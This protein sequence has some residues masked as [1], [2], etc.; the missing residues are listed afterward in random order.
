[1]SH[2]N[3]LILLPLLALAGD[4]KMLA[5]QTPAVQVQLFDYAGMKP[6]AVHEFVV[7]T[8]EILNGAG[9]SAQ[10]KLC[11]GHLAVSCESQPNGHRRL[12]IRVVAA[13]PGRMSNVRRPPLGQSFAGHEG[14]TYASVFV[15]RVQDAAAEANLSW[16]IVLAYAAV[17]E[18]GHLLLGD[19]AHTERGLMKANW[20]RKDFEAMSQ[21]NLHF[22]EEQARQLAT[23]YG[24]VK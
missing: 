14:G 11:R 6:S 16:V 9:V 10:V 21:N 15:E 20:D 8:Q 2:R 13:D 22:S 17:H 18:A 3:C 19:Q 12:S 23:Q 7:R 1:M 5:A 4:A 24:A